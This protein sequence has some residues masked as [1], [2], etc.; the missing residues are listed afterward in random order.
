LAHST[1]RTPRPTLSVFFPAHDEE[2]NLPDL[3]ASALR[4]LPRVADDFE[5]IVVDDGSTDGT[6]AVVES[7][8]KKDSRVRLVSHDRN[9]GYG[10][11][12]KTGFAAATKDLVFFTDGDGQFDLEELPGFLAHRTDAPVVIGYRI[13][14]KDNR[15]RR[16]NGFA[17]SMLVRTL[18]GVKSRDVDCAYKVIPRELVQSLTL[19]ADGAM[20]STELLARIQRRGVATKEVGVHHR[21]RVHGNPSGGSV[22]VILKAFVELFRLWGRLR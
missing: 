1:T 3:V 22:F 17:W 10:A 12:L 11:A 18:L 21:A 16:L 14:R 2:P 8:R 15:V 7:L 19:E 4:I 5:V 13:D 6:A 9:R 20:I